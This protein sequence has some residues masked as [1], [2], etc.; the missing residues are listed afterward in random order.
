MSTFWDR[1]NGHKLGRRRLLQGGA[2]GLAAVA[3]GCRPAA[4]PSPT[5]A[6][7]AGAPA[8]TS[9][10]TPAATAALAPKY[11]GTLL[12][13]AVIGE[14]ANKDPHQIGTAPYFSTAYSFSRLLRNKTSPDVSDTDTIPVGDLATGW[15]QPDDRT[16]VF[17][18]RSGVKWHNLPPA[19]GR[20]LTAQDVVWSW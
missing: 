11:G 6:P 17:K 1:F 13:V 16:Y 9:A 5:T 10:A 8:P 2:A 7:A 19:N 15:G 14:L 20:T 18:L 12:D 4:S 3:A